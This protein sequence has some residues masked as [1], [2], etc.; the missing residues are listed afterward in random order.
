MNKTKRGYLEKKHLISKYK[1][2]EQVLTKQARQLQTV[3]DT[4]ATDVNHLQDVITRRKDYDLKNEE[5]CKRFDTNMNAHLNS[6][7]ND[8]ET[9]SSEFGSLTTTIIQQISKFIRSIIYN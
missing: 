3:V 1:L 6:M 9:F 7:K 4:A 8:S 5:A 2:N